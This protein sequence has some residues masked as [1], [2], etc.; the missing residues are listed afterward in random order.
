[1][2]QQAMELNDARWST[3]GTQWVCRCSPFQSW[4]YSIPLQCTVESCSSSKICVN[5]TSTL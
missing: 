3:A 4:H 1:M 5:F 2:E